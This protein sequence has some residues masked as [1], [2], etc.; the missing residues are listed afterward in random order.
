MF[1]VAHHPDS[2][3]QDAA[4]VFCPHAVWSQVGQPGQVQLV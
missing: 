2:Q 1:A 3:P 4:H